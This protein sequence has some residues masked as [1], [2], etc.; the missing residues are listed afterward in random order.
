MTDIVVVGGGIVGAS[1][2]YYARQMGASCTLLERDGVASHA[3]GYAFGGLH[4]RVA[5]NPESEM[6]RFAMESFEEHRRLHD[7][8]ESETEQLSTW[9]PRTSISLAW[10]ETEANLFQQLAVADSSSSEWLDANRLHQL[11]PRI[12]SSALGGLM[13]N[14]SAEVDAKVLTE[15]LVRVSAPQL[16]FAEVVDIDSV[17]DR[18]RGVRTRQG[19]IIE[20]DT[21]VFAMG[22]WSNQAFEW[23]GLNCEVMPLKG[24]ILRLKIAGPVFQHS[25][26]TAGNYMSTKPDG[27][28]WIGTTE[29]DV[30]F[31]ETSTNYGR[32]AIMKVLQRMLPNSSNVSV[33]RQTACLRPITSDGEL[34]LG[35]VAS[36]R[37]ALVGTGGGRKGILYGP[38]MGKYLTDQVLATAR[39]ETWSTL[40]PDRFVDTS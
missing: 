23:L 17:N 11:E 21:F 16:R 36:T 34:I 14:D 31:D 38:L 20:G 4:P 22:P 7:E 12:S 37:N 1:T 9:R 26:S 15:S 27:L 5:A 35:N 25:F 29:E 2:C 6:T 33:V 18:I 8:L 39:S 13:T 3:S 10:N 40:L 32:S 19:E 28:L 24:Q 30:G